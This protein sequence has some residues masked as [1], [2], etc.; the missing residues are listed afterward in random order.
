MPLP[1]VASFGPDIR[2]VRQPLHAGGRLLADHTDAIYSGVNA[3][4]QAREVRT[5][6]VNAATNNNAYVVVVDGI[7]VT[8]TSDATATQAEIANG[9]AAA[10]EAE[11][12]LFGRFASVVSDGVNLVTLTG[13]WPGTAFTLT[14]ADADLAVALVTAA[15]SAANIAFGRC[16]ISQSRSAM[17]N[18][19]SLGL[20][21]STA[22]S[23]QVKTLVT[24]YVLDST[25]EIV[26]T[27][28]HSGKVIADVTRTMAADLPTTLGLF[29]ADLNGQL[30]ANS[31]VVTGGVTNLVLTSEVPGFEFD[32]MILPA[33]AGGASIP[34]VSATDTTGPSVSTSILRAIR[35]GGVALFDSGVEQASYGADAFY[36]PNAVVAFMKRG[37]VAVVNSQ[38]P[39]YGDPVYVETSGASAGLFYNTSSATR[40]LLPPDMAHWVKVAPESADA[41][42]ALYINA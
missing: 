21:I 32:A 14:T 9:L 34:V 15:A 18:I 42:A 40:L 17:A 6:T 27:D 28:K 30:P 11:P 7:S 29:L 23:A 41:L 37:H 2:G 8:Y 31:V 1:N 5:I 25:V 10:I 19:G 13:R 22:F 3:G 24:T 20:P 35:Q 39:A 33:Q 4:A 38:T 16:V 12:L 26:I 36:G